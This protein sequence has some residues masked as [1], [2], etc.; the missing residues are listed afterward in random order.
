[1][2]LD[3]RIWQLAFARSVNTMGL[4]L[5]M[6]FLGIYIVKTRGYPAWLYGVIAL[7]GNLSQSLS[8]A[9]AGQLSD[10]IGRKPLITTSM[11]V[12]AV[13]IAVLGVLVL[14]DAPIWA[15]AIN[16]VIT[17][18]LRGCFEPV[19]YALVADVATPEQ[20][21]AA[22]GLQRMGV[23]LGWAIGPALGG[24]LTIFMPY[25]TVFFI[26]AF[27]MLVATAVI[28][29]MEDPIRAKSTASSSPPL[30]E[31]LRT[32]WRDRTIRLLLL[33]TFFAALL[34][35]QM[36]ATFSIFMTDELALT[37]ANVGVI[38]ALNGAAV[39]ILQLPALALINRIGI[40]IALPYAAIVNTIGYALIGAATGMTGCALAM[41]V[42]TM[43]EVVLSPAHQSATA[44]LADP[45]HRGRM[46]GVIG[47]AQMLGV[48]FAPLLG[49]VLLDTIGDH[50]GAMWMIIATLGCAQT[51]YLFAFVR[52]RRALS[53][54]RA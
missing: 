49:G 32:A 15:L 12:R 22:F 8:N 35:T 23:N 24:L 29:P 30:A 54:T 13:F 28:A 16:L 50:H 19:S 34:H 21:I 37:K 27:G 42:I 47:F 40:E 2:K 45:S 52:R 33:A 5:V 25:G 53:S 7:T 1:M 4:S 18:T 10:R 36:Y 48:A 51:L 38:Y 9:W 20:R 41:L 39:L 6:T 26:A 14:L 46:F 3:R 43:G 17:S 44:E 31:A 11:L